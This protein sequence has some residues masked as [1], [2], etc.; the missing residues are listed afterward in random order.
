MSEEALQDTLKIEA[1]T[2]GVLENF[3]TVV[4]T[5]AMDLYNNIMGEYGY[6]PKNEF[7]LNQKQK[8]LS[9]LESKMFTDN[10]RLQ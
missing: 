10:A 1:Q 9:Y 7:S 3:V 6:T 2:T 4:T 8:I 5:K